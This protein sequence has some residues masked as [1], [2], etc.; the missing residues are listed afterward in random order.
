MNT[1]DYISRDVKPL[2]ISDKISKAK[3]L[4]NLLTF[5]HLPVIDKGNYIGLM[6]E[7]DVQAIVEDDKSISDYSYLYQSFFARKN[8]NW[9][10]LLKIFALN[11]S[12]IIPVVT[13]KLNYLGYYELADILNIFNST[14]FLNQ[15]GGVMVVSKDVSDYSFSEISQI[16][17]TNNAKIL[18]AFVSN[19]NEENVEVT[20]KISDHD[21][22]NTIQSFRRYNYNILNSFH[23]DEYLNTLK[24]R[25]DYLQ[26]YLDI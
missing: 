26:K 14:P 13:E 22:N 6:A 24:E 7:N 12:T 23:V 5:T 21:L 4:F 20:V 8:T 15:S 10:E 11:E 16:I 1:S 18:G 3:G 17:E 19:I 2:L 9:F 25:S